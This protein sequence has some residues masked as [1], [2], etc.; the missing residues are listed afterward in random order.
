MQLQGVTNFVGH[1]Q[2]VAAVGGAAPLQLERLV[3]GNAYPAIGVLRAAQRIGSTIQSIAIAEVVDVKGFPAFVATDAAAGGTDRCIG[4]DAGTD[5]LV[6]QIGF[7]GVAAK[8]GAACTAC[9]GLSRSGCE[10]GEAA[11][12]CGGSEAKGDGGLGEFH[13]FERLRRAGLLSL[14]VM[15][16]LSSAR[17][18]QPVSLIPRW[19][20]CAHSK[21]RT[22]ACQASGSPLLSMI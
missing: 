5:V 17:V 18:L 20:D 22:W 13:G 10:R 9:G 8:Q 4:S 11:E 12:A 1:E 14:P 16:A 7:Q 6:V 15:H 3:T 2:A 21:P 19:C